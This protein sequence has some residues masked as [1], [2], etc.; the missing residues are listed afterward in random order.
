MKGLKQTKKQSNSPKKSR[1][2]EIVK[3]S[4]EINQIETKRTIKDQQEST[5]PIADSLRK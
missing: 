4:A 1:L 2:L 5:R 3:I